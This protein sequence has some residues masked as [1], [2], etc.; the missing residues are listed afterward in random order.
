MN[1]WREDEDRSDEEFLIET[2]YSFLMRLLFSDCLPKCVFSHTNRRTSRCV[3]GKINNLLKITLQ[4]FQEPIWPT[5]AS[6]LR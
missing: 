4:Y 5:L 2:V 6:P 3:S 1:E